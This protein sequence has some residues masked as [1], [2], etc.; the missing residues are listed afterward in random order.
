MK[1]C[2]NFVYVVVTVLFNYQWIVMLKSNYQIC[3]LLY[4]CNLEGLKL[5]PV[6]KTTVNFL[7]GRPI[8]S[9]PKIIKIFECIKWRMLVRL[10]REGCWRWKLL[11]FIFS[12]SRIFTINIFSQI[13]WFWH[14]HQN[15]DIMIQY[16]QQ[17]H[18]F[19][20]T[21]YSLI[22]VKCLLISNFRQIYY[23][24]IF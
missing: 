6:L 11:L 21:K 14:I 20:S 15:I 9:L 24:F 17:F 4:V 3:K 22:S 1:W 12:I 19:F 16:S 2:R 13:G 23:Q 8:S 18:R 7:R 5:G 10:T